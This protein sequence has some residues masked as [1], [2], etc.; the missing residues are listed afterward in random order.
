MKLQEAI[1]S[2][3]VLKNNNILNNVLVL[4][5]LNDYNA[6]EDM[7]SSKNVFKNIITEGY[8]EKLLFA[9][10]NQLDIQN[11]SQ[12]YLYELLFLHQLMFDLLR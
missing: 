2:V 5:I 9:H 7:M 11:L 6:F 8:M 3:I 10:D 4:N 12:K 1:K